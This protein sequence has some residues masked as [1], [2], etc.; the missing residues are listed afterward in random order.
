MAL[1]IFISQNP[2]G[3][4]PDLGLSLD[5]APAIYIFVREEGAGRE[6]AARA[7][8]VPAGRAAPAAPQQGRLTGPLAGGQ[9]SA[10]C[11]RK[12]YRE[13]QTKTTCKCA[14]NRQA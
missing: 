2:P 3:F 1:V 10:P 8:A 9:R 7:D 11:A 4:R 5:E 6:G 14:R 12:G 13:M